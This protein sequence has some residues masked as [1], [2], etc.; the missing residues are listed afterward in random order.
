M[1]QESFHIDEFGR[2]IR[3]LR[4][5][6]VIISTCSFVFIFF[7]IQQENPGQAKNMEKVLITA[8]NNQ[9]KPKGSKVVKQVKIFK[10]EKTLEIQQARLTGA[11][12]KV[13]SEKNG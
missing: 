2:K 10:T 13:Y 11:C 9:R 7:Q 4:Y 12:G 5:Q 8:G 3:S 6:Y 1:F